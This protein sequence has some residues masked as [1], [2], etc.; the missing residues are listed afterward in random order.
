MINLKTDIM[1][2]MN[3]EERT[4]IYNYCIKN[5]TFIIKRDNWA[6]FQDK[7]SNWC[8]SIALPGTGCGNSYFG[9]IDYVKKLYNL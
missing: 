8:Y 4:N 6:I 7:N 3:E 2:E 9:T 1:A 5:L